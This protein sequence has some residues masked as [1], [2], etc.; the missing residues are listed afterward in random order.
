VALM[1]DTNVWVDV[2][3]S[4]EAARRLLRTA[5]AEQTDILFMS[6]VCRFE[7]ETGARFKSRQSRSQAELDTLLAGSLVFSDFDQQA[8][9]AAADL[10]VRAMRN[11][12][13]L[14]AIDAMIAGHAVACSA[15]LLTRDTR[16]LDALPSD[17]ALRWGSP[18]T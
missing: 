3:R 7:L 13:Q 16:L 6:S 8:A 18:A 1:P 9:V 11:G 17:L 12:Q 2:L 15:S 5:K 4:D 14:S 10:A